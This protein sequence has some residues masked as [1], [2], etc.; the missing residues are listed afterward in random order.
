MKEI[1]ELASKVADLERRFSGMMRHGTVAEVYPDKQTM[2]LK[3]G[4]DAQGNDFLSP[5]IPYGQT[6]GAMKFHN[7]PSV[8]QQMTMMAPNG[9]FMQAVAIPM[10]WSDAN[11]SPNDKGDEHEMTFGSA[12]V[13]LKSNSL[14]IEIGNSS[15][16]IESAKIT[17][18]SD[19]VHAV[20]VTLK[21]NAKNVGD[22]HKHLGVVPGGGITD[23]P[24]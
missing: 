11:T 5:E 4:V 15:I 6:A 17:L 3:I 8:G 2:R 12:R 10:H 21:H 7:P 13:L 19:L 23:V 18:S 9:D 24:V 14:L 16:L 1:V 20:G 22:D